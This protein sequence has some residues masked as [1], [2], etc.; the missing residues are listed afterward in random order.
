ME[1]IVPRE[2]ICKKSSIIGD[3]EQLVKKLRLIN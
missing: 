3:K 2:T 1:W